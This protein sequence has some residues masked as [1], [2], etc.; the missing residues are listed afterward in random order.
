MVDL[1]MEGLVIA[2]SRLGKA[3][4]G[5]LHPSKRK[6]RAL[7]VIAAM[8][9]INDHTLRDI[10]LYRAQLG[11]VSELSDQEIRSWYRAREVAN[12]AGGMPHCR[13][14]PVSESEVSRWIVRRR[15]W[16]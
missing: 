15:T 5:K 9:M 13:P 3:V 6:K 10:G 8:S 7:E 11:V 2:P 1:L 16:E 12:E 4:A 14:S